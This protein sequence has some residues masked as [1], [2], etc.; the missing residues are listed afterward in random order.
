ML[1]PQTYRASE[2]LAKSL[3]PSWRVS[4]IHNLDHFERAGFPVRLNSVRELGLIID[5]M[6]E[7]RFD[8]YMKELV[9]L[10][11]EEHDILLLACLDIVR[12]QLTF[13]PNR[14]PVLPIS[15]L[16]SAVALRRKLKGID[17]E[18][19]SLL[20]IGPGCGYVSFMMRHHEALENYSQIEACE[21]FYILQNWVNLHCFGPDFKECALLPENVPA[22]D[23]FVNNRPDMEF[24]P[25]IRMPNK[26]P[27]CT[28]YPWWRIGEL[29]SQERQFQII[30][31]NANLL[32]FNRPA[33]DDYLSLISKSLDTNGYLL[34]Q[35]T[36]FPASGNVPDLLDTL[37]AKGFAQLMFVLEGVPTQF[38]K[39]T[40]IASNLGF[41]GSQG[42]REYTTNNALFVKNGHPLFKKYYDRSNVGTHFI[43]QEDV[44]ENTFFSLPKNR[45]NYTVSQFVEETE[46]MLAT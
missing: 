42:L 17:P 35:C 15:T 31:S 25:N 2:T 23:Y 41:S 40:D 37:H 12:F 13:L 45:S 26:Q 6:Q 1:D 14:K 21:S 33:L 27:R 24:S 43:A 38:G 28:H 30:M 46:L 32:E 11:V 9:G 8:N 34:V 16:L 3:V 19:K 18:F 22:L 29:I 7:N 4:Q 10:S 44:V 5:T 20:E 36:G 39:A